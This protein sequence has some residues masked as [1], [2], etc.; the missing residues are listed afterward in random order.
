MLKAKYLVSILL[1]ITLSAGLSSISLAQSSSSEDLEKAPDFEV[2]TL[3][4]N[5]VSLKQSIEANKPMV[6]YFTVSW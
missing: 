1:F 5:T 6:V 4:G 2:I 3:E